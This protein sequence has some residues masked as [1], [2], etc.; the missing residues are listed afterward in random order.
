MSEQEKFI[1]RFH[2]SDNIDEVFTNGCC[3][4]FAHILCSR[5]KEA[6]L[7]YDPIAN[8]FMAQFGSRLFDITGDVTEKYNTVLW[9]D[10]DDD[11]ERQ[12]IIRD[13]INF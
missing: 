9:R 7:A 2:F 4:W 12:R 10:F 8:H 11:L 6:Q 13:C 1:K 3:Y 5:F